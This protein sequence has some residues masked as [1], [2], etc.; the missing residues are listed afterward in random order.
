MSEKGNKRGRVPGNGTMEAEI[1][2]QH[3]GTVWESTQAASV[4]ESKLALLVARKASEWEKL[5]NQY[6]KRMPRSFIDQRWGEERKQNKKAVNVI[7]IS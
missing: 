4:T 5:A 7:S 6:L 1:I 3:E 2:D